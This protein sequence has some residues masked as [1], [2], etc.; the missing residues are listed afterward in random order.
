M[1][2][3][4]LKR[5]FTTLGVLFLTAAIVY[6]S[7]NAFTFKDDSSTK[8]RTQPKYSNVR[9]FAKSPADFQKIEHAGLII[10]HAMTKAGQ[11]SDTWLSEQE[12]GLLN[13]SGIPYEI[14]IDDWDVYYNAQPRMSQGEMDAAIQ[15]SAREF[16][17]SHSIYGSMGGYLTY[18]EVIAKLDSMRLQFPQFIST[19]FSIGTTTEGRTMWA[20]RITNGPNAPTG[21]PEVLYHALI[22]AREPES[23]ETQMYYFYWLFENY[24]TNSTATY[25]LNNR[26]IYWIPVFNP[27]GYE[28]NHTTNPN[29]GGNVEREQT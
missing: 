17:V 1:K 9:I 25:I 5:T 8:E 22:H 27:D 18:S 7:F 3:T 10:E 29:G 19:K 26:E 6:F 12:I 21:R 23:M 14:L 20:V 13:N 28:Y 24:G 2:K 11:Y 16:S 4:K 15:K